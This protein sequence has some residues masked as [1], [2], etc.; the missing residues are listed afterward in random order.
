MTRIKRS[1]LMW[2]LLVIIGVAPLLSGGGIF[3]YMK[4]YQDDTVEKSLPDRGPASV[5]APDGDF[6]EDETIAILTQELLEQRNR[7]K[8]QKQDNVWQKYSGWLSIFGTIN[9]TVMGWVMAWLKIRET[10]AKE[11]QI[12]QQDQ[13]QW[14]GNQQ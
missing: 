14:R 8:E 7:A 1:V 9:T 6:D 10:R 5:P 3:A 11:Q 12:E 13:P 4:F 2:S